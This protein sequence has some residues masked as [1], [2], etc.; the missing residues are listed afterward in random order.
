M[1]S[2][3]SK[4]KFE[5]LIQDEHFKAWVLDRDTKSE[6]TWSVD[7]S[8]SPEDEKTLHFAK[9]FL[10]ALGNPVEN[11]K[12]SDLAAITAAVIASDI[13]TIYI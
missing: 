1:K 7:I 6:T 13:S 9:S 8:V 12:K 10:L 2:N 4:Y 3:S 11:S 5:D